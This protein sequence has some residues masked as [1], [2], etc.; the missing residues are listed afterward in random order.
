MSW[1]PLDDGERP[2]G[3]TCTHGTLVDEV[4]CEECAE[5]FPPLPP[6]VVPQ[7]AGQDENPNGEPT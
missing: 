5:M 2:P 6:V 4:D 7:P 1:E 3:I